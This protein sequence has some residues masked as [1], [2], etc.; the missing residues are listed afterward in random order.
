MVATK[1]KSV[2]IS[3]GVG[4]RKTSVASVHM[5]EGSKKIF[6]NGKELDK[7]FTSSLDVEMIQEPLKVANLDSYDFFAF[8]KGGGISGQAGAV[9]HGIARALLAHNED[10]RTGLK[11][12]GLLKRDPRKK[13]RKKYGR[14]KARKGFQFSKR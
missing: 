7:Y 14:K 12:E 11:A 8:V 6:V 4:K 10:L 13:E 2:D 3:N 5:R 9:R 1:K